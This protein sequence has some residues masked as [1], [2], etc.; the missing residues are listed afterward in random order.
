MPLVVIVVAVVV[1]L[2]NI[3]LCLCVSLAA[4]FYLTLLSLLVYFLVAQR[5]GSDGS[6]QAALLVAIGCMSHKTML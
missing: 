5:V 3:I 6:L 4:N 1:N 2:C